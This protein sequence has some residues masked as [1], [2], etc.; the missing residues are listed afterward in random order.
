MGFVTS[1]RVLIHRV[2]MS[3]C[4]EFGD[5]PFQNHNRAEQETWAENMAGRMITYDDDGK[6]VLA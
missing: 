5:V 1:S 4:N 6:I 3:P 2:Y